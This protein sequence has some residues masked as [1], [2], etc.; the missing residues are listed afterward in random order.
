MSNPAT[1]HTAPPFT[2]ENAGEMARRATISREKA[3]AERKALENQRV[4]P[5][6]AQRRAQKEVNRVLGWMDKEKDREKFA[7]LA[8]VLDRLWNKAY[9]T[10]G[11]IK[12][13][14]PHFEEDQDVNPAAVPLGDA[15]N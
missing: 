12:G 6:Y 13:R 4:N 2:A 8:V 9:P 3:R 5:A 10:H 7:Q 14:R 1:L 15:Q 11:A